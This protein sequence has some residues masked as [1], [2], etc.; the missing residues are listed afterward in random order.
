MKMITKGLALHR[1]DELVRALQGE[2]DE[3]SI[4]EKLLAWHRDYI[5]ALD[6]DTTIGRITILEMATE[7]LR[8][9]VNHGDISSLVFNYYFHFVN[10]HLVVPNRPSLFGEVSGRLAL[11]KGDRSLKHGERLTR[12]LFG[13]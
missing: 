4:G 10:R 8:K 11:Y 12:L 6:K 7:I 9:A 13:F 3:R 1:L 5:M 2:S